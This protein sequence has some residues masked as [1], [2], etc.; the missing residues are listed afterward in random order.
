VA[1]V[2]P[3]SP[4]SSW[5]KAVGIGGVTTR[6]VAG[7]RNCGGMNVER[8]SFCGGAAAVC[9]GGGG[10]AVAGGA[11]NL[12]VNDCDDATCVDSDRLNMDGDGGVRVAAL[13]AMCPRQFP[14]NSVGCLIASFVPL[15]VGGRGGREAPSCFGHVREDQQQSPPRWGVQPGSP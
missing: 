13:V 4:P 2:A 9:V 14:L 11:M 6:V 1:S 7:T 5:C 12:C 10:G 3:P 15:I 8:D